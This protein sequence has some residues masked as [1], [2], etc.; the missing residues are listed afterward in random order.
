[1]LSDNSG[2]YIIGKDSS[3]FAPIIW[4]YIFTIAG[5]AECK[6]ISTI[7]GRVYNQMMITDTQFFVLG[8]YSGGGGYIKFIMLRFN[9]TIED[10]RSQMSWSSWYSQV[11]E[12]I[13]ST[14]KSKI[15]I[16]FTAGTNPLYLY[17][18]TLNTSDGTTINARYKSS[19]DILFVWGMQQNDNYIITTVG[20]GTKAY[21]ILLNKS[22]NSFIIKE[23]SG[24]DLYQWETESIFNRVIITG[25]T[26]SGYI[27]KFTP[28]SI[29]THSDFTSASW[30]M[31]TLLSGTG[32]IN[33]ITPL[34]LSTST[35]YSINQILFINQSESYSLIATINSDIY[36]Q[37][38]T[39][40]LEIDEN[41]TTKV[42]LFLT[43]SSN[44]TFI[45]YT[46]SSY[47]E[48]LVP[49]WISIDASTGVM[50]I[51]SPEVSSNID[52]Y[53]Y[54]NSVVSG[55][56]GPAKKLMKL[57]VVNWSIWGVS[58][59]ANALTF[60]TQAIVGITSGVIIVFSFANTSAISSFWSM[61]GQAQIFLFLLITRAAIPD[62]IKAIIEGYK[63]VLDPYQLISFHKIH[64]YK[65]V[66]D[67]FNFEL[68]NSLLAN[69]E[70]NSDS[71]IYNT[72]S[73]FSMMILIAIFHIFVYIL[74]LLFAKDVGERTKWFSYILKWIIKKFFTVLTFGYYVRNALEMNQYLLISSINEIYVF[75]TTESLKVVSLVFAFWVLA[76]CLLLIFF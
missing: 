15:Y 70:I 32:D 71:S 75:K 23:F 60:S 59:T 49:S 5:S 57:K 6:E 44:S 30:T 64:L 36:Y 14:N 74:Y 68:S 63:I 69:L 26:G 24:T 45:N 55:F 8:A 38:N 3:A 31:D 22:A 76:L 18:A 66:I 48:T 35:L 33:S 58:Q 67:N 43:W 56:L 47:N 16:F 9:N 12:S 11:S 29:T 39:E 42:S 50:S 41:K 62:D 34:S 53:F 25:S 7:S 52:Y 28:D 73:F 1:M 17:F 61:I 21:L 13:F 19:I 27:I 4:K 40:Y 72:C 20:T 65:S 54:V 51:S 10:W 46:L 2:Y 37:I